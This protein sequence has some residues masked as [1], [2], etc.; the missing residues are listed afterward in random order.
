MTLY[1]TLEPC[2]MCLGA[3]MS[4]GI[5]RVVFAL[6]APADGAFTRLQ[7]VAFGDATYSEYKMPE[8]VGGV[9]EEESRSLFRRCINECAD[10]AL[11]QFATGVVH[12]ERYCRSKGVPDD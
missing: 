4:F 3:A 11:I 2:V 10:R 6:R 9:L 1:T 5:G 8:L 7:G 12:G